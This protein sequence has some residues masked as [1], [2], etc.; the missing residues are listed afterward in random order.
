MVQETVIRDIPDEQPNIARC[1][2]G[3]LFPGERAE[4]RQADIPRS[5]T[6]EAASGKPWCASLE[7]DRAKNDASAEKDATGEPV[8]SGRPSIGRKRRWGKRSRGFYGGRRAAFDLS[9]RIRHG[10]SCSQID[11]HGKLRRETSARA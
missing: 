1:R 8:C 3:G 10:C 2:T 6:D 11:A 7:S 4:K 5:S 9:A